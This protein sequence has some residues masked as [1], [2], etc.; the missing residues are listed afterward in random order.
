[1]CK[2]K[3]RGFVCEKDNGRP[4]AG[5]DFRNWRGGP[6]P[7]MTS[8]RA[9]GR[10]PMGDARPVAGY[11][12]PA[13]SFFGFILTYS[14]ARGM[15][16]IAARRRERDFLVHHYLVPTSKVPGAA[17]SGTFFVSRLCEVC[18]TAAANRRK[19]RG[20]RRRGSRA[21]PQ[22]RRCPARCEGWL[23]RE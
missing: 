21:G 10:E 2:M 6:S 13:P 3:P 12:P 17:A 1:M 23:Q 22:Y 14:A 15:V 11:T 20:W 8:R 19:R 5:I 4:G 16:A 7:P 9:E 18:E